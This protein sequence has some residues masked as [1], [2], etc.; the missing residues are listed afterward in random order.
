MRVWCED[1]EGLVLASPDVEKGGDED[2]GD[3][4]GEEA[5]NPDRKK[6]RREI[7]EL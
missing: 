7:R 4:D 3:E 5:E 6:E 2:G 1:L